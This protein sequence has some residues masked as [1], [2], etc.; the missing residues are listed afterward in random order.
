[1]TNSTRF[2][3]CARLHRIAFVVLMLAIGNLNIAHAEHT[4]SPNESAAAVA[5]NCFETW[6]DRPA[7]F[8]AAVECMYRA[9]RIASCDHSRTLTAS[10]G[11]IVVRDI[12]MHVLGW[13]WEFGVP[14][15]R[16]ETLRY[17]DGI[18]KSPFMANNLRDGATA[19]LSHSQNF[20][21]SASSAASQ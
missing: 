17:A 19:V 20:M 16:P 4:V 13:M 12:I 11:K 14:E 1:M 18:A 15:A 5:V 9:W 10:P 2:T 21:N 7:D 3:K 6:F 8:I